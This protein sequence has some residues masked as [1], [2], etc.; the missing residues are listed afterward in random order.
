MI[1]IVCIIYIYLHVR[2]ASEGPL[3]AARRGA[4]LGDREFANLLCAIDIIRSLSCI[5]IFISYMIISSGLV[6]RLGVRIQLTYVRVQT[7]YS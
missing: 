7:T 5:I 6:P 4:A 1:I 2:T 3:R